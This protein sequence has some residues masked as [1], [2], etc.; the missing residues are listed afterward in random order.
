MAGGG[1]VGHLGIEPAVYEFL[2]AGLAAEMFGVGI[3]GKHVFPGIDL[4]HVTLRGCVVRT[5][6]LSPGQP[7]VVDAAFLLA[8]DVAVEG[9]G[10][11]HARPHVECFLER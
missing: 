1:G 9:F 5:V 6:R 10:P 8:A 11:G 4:E 3:M 2:Q 7:P